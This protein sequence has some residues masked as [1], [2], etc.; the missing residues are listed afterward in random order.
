MSKENSC[1]LCV[2]FNLQAILNYEHLVT[3]MRLVEPI[4][5]EN[6]KKI[7]T[8]HCEIRAQQKKNSDL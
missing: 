8:F 6:E 1:L 7:I 4:V 5:Y 2:I 3:E